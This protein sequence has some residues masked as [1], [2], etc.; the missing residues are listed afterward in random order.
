MGKRKVIAIIQARLG[1][2]RLPL[3]S[4]LNLRGAPVIDW[5]ARRLLKASML[6]GI[7]VAIPDTPLDEAL[8]QHLEKSRFP[9]IKGPENDVLARYRMAADASGADLVV[10]VCADNPLIWWEAI[11]RLV[12]FYINSNVDYAYNHIPR[13]NLW[14]DGLGGEIIS[15]ELLRHL[16]ARAQTPAQREHCL[17][18]ILDN[19]DDFRIATFNPR[20]NWLARPDLKLDLD[21]PEDYR[22]LA[23]APVDLESGA[24]EIIAAFG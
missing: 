19:Q 9:W 5:V 7:I 10:R 12:D 2:T 11:D 23:L 18:Y 4:L 15:A 13:G 14:P 24:K 3:K 21:S 6:S 17:N 1:S 20:E 8:A 22:K 16:D